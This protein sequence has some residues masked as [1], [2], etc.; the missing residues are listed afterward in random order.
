MAAGLGLAY[1]LPHLSD[2]RTI[3]SYPAGALHSPAHQ[4]RAAP[5]TTMTGTPSFGALASR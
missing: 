3:V 1:A 2:Q 5:Y 4:S